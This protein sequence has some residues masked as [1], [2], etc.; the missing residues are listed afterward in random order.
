MIGNFRVSDSV[1]IELNLE[2]TVQNRNACM[3]LLMLPNCKT[4]LEKK[5]LVK[6]VDVANKYDWFVGDLVNAVTE[7]SE[8]VND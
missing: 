7:L 3:Y 4:E 8:V 5:Y 1:R 2:P 6:V